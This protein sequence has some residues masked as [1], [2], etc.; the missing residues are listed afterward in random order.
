MPENEG[1]PSLPDWPTIAVLGAGAVGCYF[2][3]LLARAGAPVTLIG[4]ANHVEAVAA[5]GLFL[6]S[7]DFRG[8]I[9]VSASTDVAAASGADIVLFCVKTVD[10][11]DAARLLRP[12]VASS[13]LV[14]SLQNGVDNVER[15]RSASGIEAIP[16]V[17]YVAAE[18]TGPGRLKHNGRGDLVIEAENVA[19]IFR[20]AGIPCVISTNIEGELWMKLIT[21][22]AYNAISA[23]ARS[24]YLPIID[25]P[26][27]RDVMIEAVKETI[28]VASAAGVQLPPVDPVETTLK[29]A[30]AMPG[31][32]S[33]TA[34][35][36]ARGR[37]TEIDSLNGYVAHR[38]AEVGVPTPVNHT[39]HALVKLLE[40]NTNAG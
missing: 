18:M 16:S 35:D 3:G 30:R 13:A 40:Q 4:R 5:K 28:A 23:L 33:S 11:E 32:I 19:A 29:L 20:R 39:L 1:T 24:K 6:E 7:R 26:E 25:D 31:A 36:L 17:V 38:G 10:T 14:V 2:G 34:Q 15:I 37:R 12:H 8:Y 27:T 22:C 9:P 21:N